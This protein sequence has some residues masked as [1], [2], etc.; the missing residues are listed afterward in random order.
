[1]NA[2]YTKCLEILLKTY[3]ECEFV[4]IS[5]PMS[6]QQSIKLIPNTNIDPENCKNANEA[7]YTR[8]P[9]P[10]IKSPFSSHHTQ[11]KS[12]IGFSVCPWF[13]RFA[14]DFPIKSVTTQLFEVETKLKNRFEKVN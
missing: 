3:F 10:L 14:F 5:L 9:Q 4:E 2:I 1:M 6:H 8:K 12:L 13:Q 11:K 7:W